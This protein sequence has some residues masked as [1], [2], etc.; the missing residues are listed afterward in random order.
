VEA[1][2]AE[3]AAGLA[4]LVLTLA[5]LAP[6]AV[7]LAGWGLYAY[8]VTVSAVAYAVAWAV[9]GVWRRGGSAGG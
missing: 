5:M 1:A 9:T 2:R 7:R 3:R 8:W 6:Y 4:A